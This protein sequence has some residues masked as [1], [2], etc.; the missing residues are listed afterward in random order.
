MKWFQRAGLFVLILCVAVTAS[1]QRIPITLIQI[2]DVYEISPVQGEGG[3]ARLATL[4]RQLKQQNPRTFLLLAGDAFSPSA[5]G[6]AEVDGQ[7]MDG[8]QMVAALNAANLDYATFGNHEFDISEQHFHQRL[9]ES[10]AVWFSGNVRDGQGKPFPRVP[11]SVTFTVRAPGGARVRIGLI[12]VTLDATKKVWV[13]YLDPIETARQQAK[14]LRPNVDIL[15]AVTHLALSQ[16]QQLAAAV[17]E[18]DLILGG[19]EHENW[20]IQRGAHFTPIMKADANARSVYIHQLIYDTQTRKLQ[21]RSTLRRITPAI[22][23]DPAA[24]RVVREWTERA[25]Q[26][27]RANGFAPDQAVAH[28]TEPL[29]GKESSVR[30]RPTTLTDLIA[31]AMLREWPGADAAVFNS[32]AIRIDD[33]IPPGSITQYDILRILPFGGKV[34]GVEM[35]GSLLARVLDAGR[36][37]VG[38]G[39]FLQL[40]NIAPG[41][42]G[43]S[44]SVA[45]HPLDPQ[46]TYRI[47]ITDFLMT[48]GE[49]GIAFLTRDAEGVEKVTEL[50]DIRFALI[51][52]MKSRWR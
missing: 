8:A 15:I 29:D 31:K 18:L 39:G 26:A 33:V 41:A 30:N 50:H 3:I 38:T 42:E 10:R 9:A 16:D 24:A 14:S 37:N 43:A 27:F 21:I 45:G 12:G 5:L 47:A 1:A 35:K 48:G 34:L 23:E 32:G 44:W 2:N 46:K 11:E 25:Y 4:R 49:L 22:P 7:K 13:T 51:E 52:E 20:Q 40:A 28:A 19:H 17:P 36:G 6:T